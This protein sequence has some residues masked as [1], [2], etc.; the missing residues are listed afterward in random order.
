MDVD[1]GCQV[2]AATHC[3]AS[4][5]I[6]TNMLLARL[7]TKQAKPDGVY[8]I[9]AA[10]AQAAVAALPLSDLPGIGWS[11]S[12]KLGD[13]GLRVTADVLHMST[14]ERLQVIMIH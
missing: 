12:Q 3:T 1:G 13:M 14:L 10:D 5:G 4:A 11:L 7:A 9:K 2:F 8:R 6:G